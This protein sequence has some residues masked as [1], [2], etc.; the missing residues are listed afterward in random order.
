VVGDFQ[1]KD[2]RFVP[3]RAAWPL[4]PLLETHSE[5]SG[6]GALFLTAALPGIGIAARRRQRRRPFWLFAV[7]SAVSIPAWWMLTQHEPR[8]LLV[9]WGLAFA[10]VPWTLVFIPRRLRQAA[11]VVVVIAGGFSALV[12]VDA[13]L[14][15]RVRQPADRARFYDQ[16]WGIDPAVAGRPGSDAIL[17]N[18]GYANLSYAGDYP[19]LGPDLTRRLLTVDANVSTSDIVALMRRQGVSYA[20]VPAASADQ[21]I[22]RAKYDA[23]LF[24][25]DH[26]ST[27]SSSDGSQTLRY[28]FRLRAPAAP[29]ALAKGPRQ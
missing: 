29:L 2:D 11:L 28:L 9:L 27:V 17:Y 3:T 24:D 1:Q 25:L 20:Y 6:L 10:F 8:H 26:V 13:A 18:T 14:R 22:V 21:D 23:R 7:V 4:Y 19:L 12:T 15:P 16:V 5:E